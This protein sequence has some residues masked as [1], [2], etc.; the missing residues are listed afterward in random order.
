MVSVVLIVNS[1]FAA[2]SAYA[3][4]VKEANTLAA[5]IMIVSMVLGLANMI[6]GIPENS[7]LYLVPIYNAVASMGA[8]I[9]GEIVILNLGLTIVSNIVFTVIVMLGITRMFNS[10]KVMFNS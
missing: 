3:K 4:T 7:L 2:L 1:I 6:F 5:P 9:T 8:I 10:E